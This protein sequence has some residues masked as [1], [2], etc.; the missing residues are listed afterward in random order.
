MHQLN[1]SLHLC[2]R[3]RH[4]AGRWPR[5]I[6]LPAVDSWGLKRHYNCHL[7][8]LEAV[9]TQ[10]GTHEKFETLAVGEKHSKF[11]GE[12]HE[13]Q[14]GGVERRQSSEGIENRGNRIRLIFVSYNNFKL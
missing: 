1:D 12:Q 6:V 3:L 14:R 11:A 8:L 4:R 7:L 10:C 5:P 2:P 13:R 9:R